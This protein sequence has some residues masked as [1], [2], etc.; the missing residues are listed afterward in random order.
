[1]HPYSYS[2]RPSGLRSIDRL[3]GAC[4]L[5]CCCVAEGIPSFKL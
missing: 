3:Q 5:A 2:V 4:S 1:M